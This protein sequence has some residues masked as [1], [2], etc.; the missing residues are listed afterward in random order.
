M[1][2]D[3]KTAAAVPTGMKIWQSLRATLFFTV[4]ALLCVF[5]FISG[6]LL[7]PFISY[8]ARYFY[9]HLHP[10]LSTILVD[11][12]CGLKFRIN[13]LENLPDSPVILA[14]KHQTMWETLAIAAALDRRVIVSVMKREL[15]YVPFFGWGAALGGHILIRRNEGKKAMEK[16]VVQG[17]KH[18]QKGHSILLFPEG[19]RIPVGKTGR[20]NAGAAV[21][22]AKS[23]TPVVPVAH[24]AGV[25]WPLHSLIMYPGTITVQIG[26][27]IEVQKK[28]INEIRSEI[29]DRLSGM[30]SLL[31]NG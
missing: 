27:P 8:R 14:V 16:L 4:S 20:I 26:K 21:L 23:N 31:D 24:N 10:R 7:T 17:K 15:L 29:R 9:L 1:S 28:S 12:I 30:M 22:A 5:I 19:T 6:L 13:G 11:K 2:P 3:N 25:Y 18:L